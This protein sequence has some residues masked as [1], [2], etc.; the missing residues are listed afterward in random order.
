MPQPAWPV[1]GHSLA[2]AVEF[3]ELWK[4]RSAWTK[5]SRKKLGCDELDLYINGKGIPQMTHVIFS[6]WEGSEGFF[7]SKPIVFD[8]PDI[9]RSNPKKKQATLTK[10]KPICTVFL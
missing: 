1:P 9:Q 8:I 3:Y 5:A 7:P 10:G 6:G 2:A 4:H